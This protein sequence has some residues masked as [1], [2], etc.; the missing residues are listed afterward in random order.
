LAPAIA[1]VVGVGAASLW[2]GRQHLAAA[3][4]LAGTVALTAVWSFV[5]LVRSASW[6]P[7][8]RYAVLLGGLVAAAGIAGARLLSAR[9]AAAV[10]GL[11]VVASLAG[12][13]A[14]SIQTA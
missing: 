2:R 9:L 14:Y 12:P 8:L 7:W 3:L 5:L 13:A 6:H 4:A 1:A 11:A 10:A